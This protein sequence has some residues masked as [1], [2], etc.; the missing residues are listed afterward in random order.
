MARN[1]STTLQK[2]ASATGDH[3]RPGI[4]RRAANP[5]ATHSGANT[6]SC[7]TTPTTA[8]TRIRMMITGGFSHSSNAP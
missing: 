6:R 4:S 8:H 7:S 3:H 5:S 2:A 1:T